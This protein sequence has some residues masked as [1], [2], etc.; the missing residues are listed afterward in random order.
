MSVVSKKKIVNYINL[1]IMAGKATPAPPVGPVLSQNKLNIMEF[2]K[3][4][5]D[6]T[7]EMPSDALIPVVITVYVDKTFSFITK[8]PPVSYFVRKAA[9]VKSGSKAP[10]RDVAGKISMAQV[11]EIA[12]EK[13]EDMN[14]YDEAAAVSMVLGT[15]R[16]M[17]IE[18]VEG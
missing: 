9:G 17:G 7:K 11:R 14:A 4:F 16:S 5:N 15:I 2:C 10:G 13:L 12:Q 18:V 1:Q 3:A 6:R 8:K